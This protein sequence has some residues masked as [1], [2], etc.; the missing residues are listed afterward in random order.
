VFLLVALLAFGL[1]VFVGMA[2]DER[3]LVQGLR[4]KALKVQSSSVQW[5]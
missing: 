5:P 3:D 4:R 2:P 1:A